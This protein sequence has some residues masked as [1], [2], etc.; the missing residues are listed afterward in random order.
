MGKFMN[1][2]LV[3]GR[4]SF[5]VVTALTLALACGGDDE[6]PDRL[7]PPGGGKAGAGGVGGTDPFGGASGIGG[8]GAGGDASTADPLRP[9]VTILAPDEVMDPSVGP[10]LVTS[11]VEVRCRATQSKAASAKPV[12]ASSVRIE[13]L[14]A[15]DKV[16]G[17]PVAGQVVTGVADEFTASINTSSVKSGAVSFRCTAAD[18]SMPP[19]VGEDRNHTFVDNGPVIVIHEPLDGDARAQ[20]RPVPIR[21]DVTPAPL[22]MGDPGAAVSTVTLNVKGQKIDVM[23]MDPGTYLANVD[24]TEASKFGNMPPNGPTEVVIQATNSR[25]PTPV[26]SEK[27]YN[28][29]LDGDGPSI[30]VTAPM[31][32]ATIGGS[33]E[34]KFT[35][36]DMFAGVTPEDVRVLIN[37][38]PYPFMR[39]GVWTEN[40][41]NFTLRFDSTT[42]EN[43][44]VQLTIN[45]I[46]KD[47]VGN[48][49]QIGHKL[50]L[51]NVPPIVDLVPGKVR[52]LRKSGPTTTYC[53][54]PFDPIGTA[55]PE[56][57]AT[58]PRIAAFRALIWEDSNGTP[59]QRFKHLSGVKA[60][61]TEL[62]AQASWAARP[63]LK[64][65]DNDG[66]CDELETV[67]VH[68]QPLNPVPVIGRA[69]YGSDTTSPPVISSCPPQNQ[70]AEP[71]LCN[72]KSDLTRVIRH[73]AQGNVPVVYAMGML[74][75]AS[76]EC[77]G[78]DWEIANVIPEGWVCVA[79][80]AVDQA[81]NI[82]ISRPIR[83][84]VDYPEN[85]PTPCAGPEPSCKD[86]C[87]VLPPKFEE[88]LVEEVP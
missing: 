58:I 85:G 54:N 65:T 71:F 7:Q 6:R 38:S 47:K 57:Q 14:D 23:E 30:K 83:L 8:A 3:L 82:G 51:D 25:Q 68:V 45:I 73:F 35:V 33:V 53:S 19:K 41:G 87:A 42:V 15:E 75:P 76:N 29:N 62:Y 70:G 84:C 43:S 64:D 18:L 27:R 32:D 9:D 56:D 78:S 69:V 36:T 2:R 13:L 12:N 31:L 21:F 22:R 11:P 52:E 80:R 60:G 50:Y 10:V 55:P 66:A 40:N 81:G 16:V 39:G 5:C 74:V 44:A 4:G 77:T 49:S 37:G 86:T 88:T 28:F 26:G 34:L 48:E 72:G 17:T 79:G 61:T 1:G 67:D 46:A 20:K 63:L 24:F 59:G